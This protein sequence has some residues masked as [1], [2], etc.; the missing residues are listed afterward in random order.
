LFLSFW[1]FSLIL[2]APPLFAAFYSQK[3][4][5]LSRRANTNSRAGEQPAKEGGLSEKTKLF[6]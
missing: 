6:K 4:D 3:I 1:L 2:I 5:I